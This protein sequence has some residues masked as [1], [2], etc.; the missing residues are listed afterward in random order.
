[1]ASSQTAEVGLVEKLPPSSG[2]NKLF[3][4]MML[5]G[6]VTF[7]LGLFTDAPRVWRSYLISNMIFVG[8]GIGAS[9]FLVLHYLAGSGWFVVIRRIPE[10]MVST[11][12]ISFVTTLVLLLGLGKLYPWTNTEMMRADHFLYHKIGYFGTAFFSIRMLLFFAVVIFF[13]TKLLKNSIR[14]DEEGGLD[15][16]DRQKPISAAFLVCF[17]PLFTLFAID[18]VKSLEPKWFSTIFGVYV[19]SGFM[20]TAVEVAIICLCLLKRA[21]FLKIVREDHV[22]DMSKYL[23]GWSVFWAYI[24]FSQY[25]LIWY[26]NL[27]EETFYFNNR[28]VGTWKWV[29]IAL[30]VVKFILPF[31]LLLPRAAKRSLR[32]AT[33][34]ACLVVFSQWLDMSWMVMPSFSPS[35]FIV[36]WQDIGLFIGF[37]GLFGFFVR[38]HLEQH[39]LVP[40][41]DPY[42][43]E[44]KDHHVVYA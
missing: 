5:I 35:G 22:H 9:V 36:G 16:R 44:S 13:T 26:A 32:F 4:G 43:H 41:K 29:A 10:A 3:I 11:L 33:G 38:R 8:L 30:L 40:L 37:A 17:A 42:M 2:V 39:N 1:M 12:R 28:M 15:L 6:L 23:F 14:Q 24:G 34:I 7:G 31:L 27:P 18:M 19:F 20:Q 21:N 25:M